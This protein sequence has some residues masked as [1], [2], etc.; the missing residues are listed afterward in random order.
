MV[1]VARAAAGRSQAA[2]ASLKQLGEQSVPSE[3]EV[4]TILLP[5]GNVNWKAVIKILV[6]LDKDIWS[7]GQRK[8]LIL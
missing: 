5:L 2:G 7:L 8:Y 6:K 3:S 1:L 4:Q